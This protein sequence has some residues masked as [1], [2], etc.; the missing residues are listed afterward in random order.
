MD[1]ELALKFI[2]KANS[3]LSL[4]TLVFCKPSRIYIVD[5]CKHGF[6]GWC[7]DGSAWCLVIPK[8]LRNRAHINLLEFMAHVIP[9]WMDIMEGRISNQDCVLVKGDSWTT[10]GWLR[11]SNFRETDKSTVDWMAKKE[12]G[13]KLAN[14]VLEAEAVLYRQWMAG[15][16]NVIADSLSR[17]SLFLNPDSHKFFLETLLPFQ[18]PDYFHLKVV[19][20]EIVSFISSTLALLPENEQRW[21]EPRPSEILLGSVGKDFCQKSECKSIYS[22]KECLHSRKTSCSALSHKLLE[23]LPSL[24]ETLTSWSKAQCLPPSHMWHRPSGQTTGK[25]TDWTQMVRCASSSTNNVEDT[26][27]W[28]KM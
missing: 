17:D 25:I 2:E 9:I 10:S 23:K 28:M 1:L 27:T 16:F 5:A 15:E 12:V 24:Q 8:H 11:R 7:A 6:G 22:L 20:Q 26:R 18:L 4:N 3:G 19:P 21:K 13:R 14:L